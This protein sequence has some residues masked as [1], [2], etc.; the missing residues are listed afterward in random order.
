MEAHAHAHIEH[1]KT[2]HKLLDVVVSV[3]ALIISAVSI[4]LAWHTGHN[5]EKLVHANSW[6]ALQIQS[7][8]SDGNGGHAL[9]F[10]ITNAGVGP[11]QIHTVEVLYDGVSLGWTQYRTIQR[12][13]EACCATTVARA[14]AADKRW[15]V[16]LYTRPVSGSFLPPRESIPLFGWQRTEANGQPWDELDRARNDRRVSVRACYCSV[17]EECWIAETDKFPPRSVG[18]CSPSQ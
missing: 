13:L 18:S 4:L 1:H 11:A 3:S 7:G 10:S 9:G 5:M 16:G 14:R 8:N 17:F 15:D 12:L 6:P 2:G